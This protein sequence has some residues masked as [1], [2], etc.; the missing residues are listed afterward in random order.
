MIE[1]LHRLFNVLDRWK[2]HYAFAAA[3]LILG[4]FVRSLTPKVIQITVDN[5]ISFFQSGGTEIVMADDAVTNLFYKVLPEMTPANLGWVLIS[6]GVIYMIISALRGGLILGASTL[7]ASST[8]NAVKRLRDRLF[9]HIQKLPMQYFTKVSRGELI[10]RSTGDID[11]VKGFIHGHVID[12]IRVIAIFTFA[13]TMIYIANPTM[14]YVSVIMSPF[15]LLSSYFF[16]KKER[17]VW[18]EHEA[19]ADKLNDI[20]QEN[21]N[22]IR[23]VKAFANESYEMKKFDGQN[24][25]KL[26][27]G[28]KHSLLHTFFWPLSDMLMYFQ[29]IISVLVGG[30]FAITQQITIGELMAFYTYFMMIAWPM[31]QIGRTLSKL[32]M[33]MVA[34]ERIYEILNAEEEPQHGSKRIER[35][36]GNIEFR[37]VS[38]KYDKEATEYTLKDV[39]FKLTPGEKVAIIGP[40]GAGKSTIINL[41]AGLYEPD[42]GEI[43]IDGENIRQF[44]KKDLRKQIGFVLQTPFLFS[45]TVKENITYASPG[46]EEDVVE[47]SAKVAQVHTIEDVL[48]DGYDTMVG[49]KGVTLSGG[50]KQR[51]ALARTLVAMPDILILDDVTSAVDTETEHA[52]FDALAEPMGRKTTILISHRITSIQQADRILVLENGRIV[53]KGNDAELE[54]QNGYYKEIHGIQSALEEEI[55]QDALSGEDTPKPPVMK[56]RK[57]Q[58]RVGL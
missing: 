24:R 11:T 44:S 2:W 30:F 58:R 54:A 49:E 29:I 20:V 34:I 35:L 14:A 51:V 16:F 28:L 25:K 43:F 42:E 48:A 18:Q 46:A 45:T 31:R 21:L 6:L 55:Q 53:Q 39:S 5:V 8:E 12:I 4:I 1:N 13:F 32:G 7:A 47:T 22:G 38:F 50:Q 57:R 56:R 10:Q 17:K 52:I 41:L 40:T 33:T 9:A 36:H 27:V 26:A 15:M 3:L 37:N 19:E 23:T